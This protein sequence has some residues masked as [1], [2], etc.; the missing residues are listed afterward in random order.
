MLPVAPA[1]AAEIFYPT[2]GLLTNSL[3]RSNS[4]L[5]PVLISL[6]YALA[7]VLEYYAHDRAVGLAV[8]LPLTLA[9]LTTI[10]QDL[11]IERAT[12]DN[13]YCV[14]H[15]ALFAAYVAAEFVGLWWRG[16]SVLAL[17]PFAVT[18]VAL[19]LVYS[20]RTASDDFD[21]ARPSDLNFANW[22]ETAQVSAFVGAR[23]LVVT[24]PL[25]Y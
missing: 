6:G 3:A 15:M 12:C 1:L 7:G 16:Y 17:L 13:F 20:A 23:V 5:L 14:L 18:A 8:S 24:A 11:L 4:A 21:V 10:D 9:A 25:Y 22:V 19:G 2:E